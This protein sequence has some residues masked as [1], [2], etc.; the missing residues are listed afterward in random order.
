MWLPVPNPKGC[1]RQQDRAKDAP[2]GVSRE[3]RD[4]LTKPHYS[5]SGD[6]SSWPKPRHGQHPR[7]QALDRLT[8]DALNKG[9]LLRGE[10]FQLHLK[11]NQFFSV[12]VFNFH[13]ARTLSL[14]MFQRLHAGT[15]APIAARSVQQQAPRI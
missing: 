15:A 2:N 6:L 1:T 3:R 4:N 13:W 12:R 7:I 8:L 5:T 14:A 9:Q 11:P 10:G